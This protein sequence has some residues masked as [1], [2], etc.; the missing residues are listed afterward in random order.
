MALLFVIPAGCSHSGGGQLETGSSAVDPGL[1]PDAER[2]DQVDTYHGVEV[3]DPYRWLEDPDAEQSREWIE[4]QNEITFSYLESI[5]KREAITDRLTQMWNYERFGVPFKE[6]GKYFFSHNDGLQNQPVLYVMD[7]LDGE[8]R[9]LLDPNTLSEDGTVSAGGYSVSP[10]GRYLAY[11]ISRGGSDWQ[12]WKVRDIETGE[13]LDDHIEWSKFS[14]ASWTEDGEGFYYSRYD[15]PAEGEK[16]QQANYYQKLYYHKV[17]TPQSEDRLVYERP[18]HKDW[19]F[20]GRVTDDGRYLIISVSKGTDRRNRVYYK[21]LESPGSEVVKLL[22]EFDASYSFIDNDGPVFWFRTDLNAPRGRVI[23]ID[24]TNPARENWEEIIPQREQ[25]LRGVDVVGRTF[26]ATYLKDARTQARIFSLDG[27]PLRVVDLPGLG[28]ARGFSGERGDPETFFT[29]TDF[30]TPGTVYRLDTA[31]GATEVFRE[32]DLQIDKDKYVTRQVF[33]TSKDGTRIPMFITH[34]RGLRR[35]GEN[36]TLLY[37]YGGFNIPITPSFDPANF[38]WMEMGGVYAVAN[39]RGGG[40]YGEQWHKAGMKL[41]KQNVFDDFIA[42][43]EWLI[44]SR[45]TSS[46][47]LAIRGRSNGGLLVGACM[48]QRP[49]LFGACLP[50]VGVL[51]ML[52]FHKF[53]IG[54]AWVSDYGSAENPEEFEVLYEYS[55]YHNVEPGTCYPPTFIVTADHDDRV[56]PAHS[57]KFAAE[58]QHAQR[59]DNPILIRIETKAGHG[60]GKPTSKRIAERADELAFLTRALEMEP[61]SPDSSLSPAGAAE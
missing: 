48:T 1:Y 11:A 30:T 35:D 15:E 8:P 42:A 14:G 23:A 18:D 2:V 59:C 27:V 54:W 17:G 51:D 29:Y 4:A 60:G 52:R 16:L 56:V 61:D 32:P 19:G 45:Y 40:E 25:T 22:N 46:S 12:E 31:T 33:Y 58:L 41:N 57:F 26:V 38:A 5:P 43:A 53:T 10:D 6:G 34:K 3:R 36:P 39:I 20:S 37:G 49:D 9:V 44:E 28:T 7:S 24:T 47:K 13:D 55:P 21:D 50:G